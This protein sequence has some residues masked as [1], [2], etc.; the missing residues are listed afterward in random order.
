MTKQ[1]ML[2]YIYDKIADKTLSF[3][4]IL[5]RIEKYETESETWIIINRNSI[6][7]NSLILLSDIWKID[8]KNKYTE[9]SKVMLEENIFSIIWHPV[10]IWDV[11]EYERKNKIF[12]DEKTIYLWKNLKN[13]IWE[14]T[15]E[16]I[17]YIYNLIK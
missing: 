5:K 11:L 16:C 13:P 17:E 4:C 7:K 1:K 6:Q 9:V 10:M 15:F 14:Q 12:L 3:G 2:E 8:W